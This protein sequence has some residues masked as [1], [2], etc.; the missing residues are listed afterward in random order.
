MMDTMGFHSVDI[1]GRNP[2]RMLS[3]GDCQVVMA[4][5]NKGKVGFEPF[6]VKVWASIAKRSGLV[7]DIGAYTGIYSLLTAAVNPT[8]MVVA[9]EPHPTT[10]GRL[11]TN[12]V[13][14]G[15][16][17]SIAPVNMAASNRS[18]HL[19]LSLY[20]GIYTMSSGESLES[21]SHPGALARKR[22]D[23]VTVDEIIL[24]WQSFYPS[25]LTLPIPDSPVS[26]VKIDVEGHERATLA[27]MSRIIDRDR[28]AM[29]VEILQPADLPEILSTLPPYDA[30]WVGERGS[31]STTEIDGGMNVIFLPKDR[32]NLRE[33]ISGDL[34]IGLT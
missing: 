19:D 6:S 17:G 9:F 12:I 33:A 4:L 5:I 23:T 7:L 2:F 18:G 20:G 34:G 26:L 22:V 15:F 27:G 8:A 24:G 21:S 14:N 25:D 3:L 1:D 16:N 28:P 31:L 11:I 30:Y 13:A 10:F 29:L 32:P